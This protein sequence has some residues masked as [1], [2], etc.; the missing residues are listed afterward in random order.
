MIALFIGILMP[1]VVSSYYVVKTQEAVLKD[2]LHS[3]IDQTLRSKTIAVSD[4]VWGY[5]VEDG[6]KLLKAA[7][8]DERIIEIK[9]YE[10]DKIFIEAKNQNANTKSLIKK[11]ASIILE[12]ATIGH[13]EILFESSWIEEKI[14]EQKLMFLSIFFLQFFFGTALML[15][16]WYFKL[17]NPIQ[18][19]IKQSEKLAKNSLDERFE[20]DREDEIGVLGKS[21]ESARV[22]I[23]E[24]IDAKEESYEEIVAQKEIITDS[25]QKIATLLDNSGEGFLSFDKELVVDT[26]YSL[27]CER[28]FG[29]SI[30]GEDIEKLLYPDDSYEQDRFKKMLKRVFD[31][32]DD[33]DDMKLEML[34]SLLPKEIKRDSSYLSA[35]YRMLESKHI[36]MV[37][38]DTTQ[39]KELQ[40]KIEREQKRLLFV[41]SSIKNKD[42]LIDVIEEFR[43]FLE[44]SSKIALFEEAYRAIHTFKGTFAQYDFYHLPKALHECESRLSRLKANGVID[45]VEEML[46]A[47]I[48]KFKESLQ[49]DLKTLDEVLGEEYFHKS[50]EVKVD[51]GELSKITTKVHGLI[52]SEEYHV[53]LNEDTM[54]ILNLFKALRYK[55]L[56]E[57]LDMYPKM[58]LQLAERLEKEIVPFLIEG[59][60]FRVDPERF[61]PFT[62]SLVHVFRNAID[63]GIETPDER[64][65]AD[66]DEVAKISCKAELKDGQLLLEISDDGRGIDK[67]KIIAKAYSLRLAV[68]EN[69][70]LLIFEDS[71][72]TKEQVTELSGRGV[73]LSA[74][75]A[76]IEKLGGRIEIESEIGKGTTFR[77]VMPL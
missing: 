39:E 47:T 8:E 74:V 25:M 66:K 36:M 70:L 63:H 4:L 59:G 16:L 73:G 26:Q 75:R 6:M 14:D 37:I 9:V 51:E 69:P 71:F 44:N 5:R 67:D 57:L 13:V 22:S 72:S 53:E 23:K 77:F 28:L 29:K 24:L 64:V 43:C 62:K 17:L 49:H 52:Y 61:S 33:D 46:K 50:S 27:E 31:D 60:E 65:E 11:S 1:M 10:K 20:W 32:D 76:E 35:K 15:L 21:F 45:G 42:E 56:R 34:L 48:P 12:D 3:F 30:A 7:L 19:L 40:E 18:K 68:P 38:N 58:S 55:P 2:E 41:V 54:E